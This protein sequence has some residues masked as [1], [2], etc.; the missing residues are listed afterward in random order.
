MNT[1]LSVQERI[2]LITL[3]N[4]FKGNI[5]GLSKIMKIVDQIEMSEKEKKEIDFNLVP[6]N[7]GMFFYNWDIKKA[8][9]KGVELDEMQVGF[10]KQIIEAKSARNELTVEDKITLKLAEKLGI[11]F[12]ENPSK[13]PE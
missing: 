5:S 11:N 6:Q 13:K 3:V 4:E 8:K 1:K 2:Q 7:N 10:I 12:D 9:D